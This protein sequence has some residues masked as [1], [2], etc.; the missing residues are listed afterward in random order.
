MFDITDGQ[1][2]HIKFAN[3]WT[4]SVQIGKGNYC[5]NRHKPNFGYCGPSNT[6]ETAVWGPDGAFVRLPQSVLGEDSYSDD[7]QGYMSPDNV[8]KILNWTAA[9]AAQ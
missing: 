1:G 2:F 5:D 6:A 9:Q 7:V 4:V 8:L 3:G